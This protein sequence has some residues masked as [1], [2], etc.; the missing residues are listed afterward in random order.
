MKYFFQIFPILI[1]ITFRLY[2][3]EKTMR[4]LHIHFVFDKLLAF[5]AIFF[6]LS[7]YDRLEHLY[8]IALG[9]FYITFDMYPHSGWFIC[10]APTERDGL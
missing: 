9:I 1:I 10:H 3:G 5:S 7:L 8:C 4:Y 2:L 6:L